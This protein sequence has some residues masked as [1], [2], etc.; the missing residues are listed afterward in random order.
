MTRVAIVDTNG[1]IIHLWNSGADVEPEGAWE[2]DKTKTVVHLTSD[3][4]STYF[5][6]HTT[7][8]MGHGKKGL[9]LQEPT[10]LGKMKPGC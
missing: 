10:I 2:S 1:E 3:V 5:T 8:K 7:I 4:E 6:Q 9:F